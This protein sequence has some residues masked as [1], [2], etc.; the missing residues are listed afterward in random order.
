M[1]THETHYSELAT[2]CLTKQK[3]K[4]SYLVLAI[5]STK[6]QLDK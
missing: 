2:D 6:Q 4:H 1:I 3:K 5:S